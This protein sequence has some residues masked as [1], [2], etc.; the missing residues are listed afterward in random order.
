MPEG[1]IC[2][3]AEKTALE[4]HYHDT[5][6]GVPCRDDN[7]QFEFLILESAQAGLSWRTI[8]QKREGYREAFAGFAPE[9]V[10]AF[11]AAEEEALMQNPAII[12][13]RLKIQAA[14]NNARAFLRVQ[15]QYGSFSNYLWG[16][17]E[18]KP[19]VNTWQS[20]SELPAQTPLSQKISRDL[21]QKKF[22]FLGPVVIYS[23]LQATGL[24]ND[25]LVSCFR[26]RQVGKAGR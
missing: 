25:H 18:N 1:R 10:A 14:I 9:L 8:L 20:L 6:W 7:R 3:W 13:N 15:E 11:S 16:F 12:R 23:H 2:P 5:E 26:Y 4:R 22:K 17:V 24:I 19:V 21:K